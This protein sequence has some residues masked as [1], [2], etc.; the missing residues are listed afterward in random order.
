MDIYFLANFDL[1]HFEIAYVYGLIDPR[2]FSGP[3]TIATA[4]KNIKDHPSE[5]AIVLI[6]NIPIFEKN[7]NS[8]KSK[9]APAPKVVKPPP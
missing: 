8:A 7:N 6:N 9:N 4:E 2:F 1:N 3:N 5:N